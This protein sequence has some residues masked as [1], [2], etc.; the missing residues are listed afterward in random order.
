MGVVSLNA[1]GCL[2]ILENTLEYMNTN[3]MWGLGNGS[4]GGGENVFRL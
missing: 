4:S 2:N 3:M 1:H